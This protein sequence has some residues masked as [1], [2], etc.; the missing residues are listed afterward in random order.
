MRTAAFHT[1]GCKVNAYET[2]AMEQALIAAG[3]ELRSFE[4]AAD[5]YIINTCSVTN[6]ADRKS[7][8]MLHRAKS[9]NPGAVVVA[10]G[11]YAQAAA[12]SLK[13]D[14]SVDLVLGNQEKKDLVRILDAYFAEELETPFA[15][16]DMRAATQ[17]EDLAANRSE[18]HT[19]AFLK[20]Q[21]GCNQYCS[22]CIIP[23]LRGNIRSRRPGE[24]RREAERLAAN[25]VR[26][27]V[28]TGIHL[29]SY[30]R[31][32]KNAEEREDFGDGAANLLELL[33]LLDSVEGIE[34]LRIGSLEPKIAT[35][36]FAAGLSKLKHFC[37]HFHLSLQSGSNATLKRMGRRY[38]AEEFREGVHAL[39]AVF[40]DAAM[41]T[42]VIVGFPGESEEAFS[43]S[44]AFIS[45]IAFYETHIFPYSKRAGTKAATMPGQ[46]AGAVKKER[47]ARLQALNAERQREFR[48]RRLGSIQEM[49]SEEI[50]EIN[51]ER[52]LIGNSRE[53]V[54]LAVPLT[55][56]SEAPETNCLYRGRAERFLD[57]E[58]LLLTNVSK[59]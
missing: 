20:V 12:E 43:E 56:L 10:A 36:A 26:E 1:L 52:Y 49:L 46:L 42:D 38:T 29:S 39:R 59:T 48:A 4:E 5:V 17:Y 57:S 27:L 6:I 54:K 9:L 44:F 18:G 33:T 34:R 35:P 47:A 58:I 31:D 41:T 30:G 24:V 11:C 19:R 50:A 55:A 15:V 53:Y 23:F 16:G 32:F 22:Y 25:G 13:E 37:P 3:Y 51:G 8:Q 28:L 2:E 7:R 14:G 45:E 40:P 21:D